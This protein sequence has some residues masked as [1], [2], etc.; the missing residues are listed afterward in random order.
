MSKTIPFKSKQTGPTNMDVRA[1]AAEKKEVEAREAF[2]KDVESRCPYFAVVGTPICALYAESL[3]WSDKALVG[4]APMNDGRTM[5]AMNQIC[6]VTITD[7]E[8]LDATRATYRKL[9]TDI[10]G[11]VPPEPLPK[12]LEPDPAEA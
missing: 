5:I 11:L 2:K 1:Y 12:H 9:L 4:I 6:A 8:A 10:F 3:V 7:T